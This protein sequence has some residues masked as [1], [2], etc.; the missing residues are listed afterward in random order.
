MAVHEV[1]E[2]K[3][4]SSLLAIKRLDK[5]D[6]RRELFLLGKKPGAYFGSWGKEK[7]LYRER[8]GTSRR[9]G[10]MTFILHRREKKGKLKG[11]CLSPS[12]E[13]ISCNPILKPQKERKTQH[14]L[15][16]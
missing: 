7:T 5:E 2:R 16:Y 12:G 14:N 3:R 4:G 1:R 11:T 6:R 9:E 10:S 8:V 13:S 15:Y